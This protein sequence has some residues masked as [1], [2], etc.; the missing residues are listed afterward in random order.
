MEPTNQ[1]FRRKMIFQASM[2][3]FHVSLP[4]CICLFSFVNGSAR[5]DMNVICTVLHVV[6]RPLNSDNSD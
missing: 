3:M 2:I 4:G 1:T 6:Y 5:G